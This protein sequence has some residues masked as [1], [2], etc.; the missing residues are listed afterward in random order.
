MAESGGLED[1]QTWINAPP[2]GGGRSVRVR[3]GGCSS[4]V[5]F[6]SHPAVDWAVV[7]Y[8]VELH[9]NWNE[10]RRGAQRYRCKGSPA[11]C[12]Y[13]SSMNEEE[14]Y[15]GRMVDASEVR[16]GHT[17]HQEYSRIVQKKKSIYTYI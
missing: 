16:R 1:K 6:F 8:L 13:G 10:N 3:L 14:Q 2:G 7:I 17:A 15:E 9:R 5:F 4:S 11:A 12:L